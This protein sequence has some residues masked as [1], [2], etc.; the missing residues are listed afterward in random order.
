M[1]KLL[2]TLICI[3]SICAPAFSK[4]ESSKAEQAHKPFIVT[5]YKNDCDECNALEMTK[6]DIMQEYGKK[7]DF[8]KLD[9][10]YDDCDFKKLKAKYNVK[11]VP[12]TL[13]I[14]IDKGITKKKEGFIS[15]KE[16]K[17]KVKAIL[18]E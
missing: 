6:E 5:F 2:I 4:K 12:T 15:Y 14:N 7:I 16:Y 1:K 10:N 3:L 13:F 18:N 9:F 17:S 8:I 11:T